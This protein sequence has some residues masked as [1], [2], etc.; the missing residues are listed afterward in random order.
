MR[1]VVSVLP[2]PQPAT[3][4][5]GEE[6]L[7]LRDIS[8]D[9]YVAFCEELGERPV[10][11]SYSQ[12]MSEIMITKAPHEFFKKM[13][14]KLVEITILERNIPVRSGGSMTFQRRDLKKGFEPDEC[15]WISSEA[16]VRGK[17]EFDF[18]RDPPPDLAIEVEVS[19]SLVD[20]IGIFAA[21][22]VRELWRFNGRQLR[23]CILRE[24]GAYHELNTSFAFPFLKPADLEQFLQP[25]DRT[26]ETTRVRQFRDWLRQ[27][28]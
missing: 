11:L 6:R 7:L 5:Q 2:T 23:F 27:Q 9:F 18:V 19:H 26:D 25:D 4:P 3:T 17:Q 21:M 16:Q 14:A 28:P 13:L 12:G 20:R 10:R 15:W 24:D 22:G 8:W 1:G